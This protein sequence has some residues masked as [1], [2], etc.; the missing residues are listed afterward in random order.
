MYDFCQG[1]PIIYNRTYYNYDNSNININ[2]DRNFTKKKN[3]GNLVFFVLFYVT[4]YILS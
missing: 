4:I 1:M 2:L 3:E